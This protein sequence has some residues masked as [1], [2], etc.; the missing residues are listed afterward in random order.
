[1][2]SGMS[3]AEFDAFLERIRQQLRTLREDYQDMGE[4]CQEFASTL[5]RC[6]KWID[7]AEKIIN[8]CP[9]CG[10]SNMVCDDY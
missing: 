10:N 6:H 9:N 2:S 1:M 4:L 8:M 5:S 3:E 7:E